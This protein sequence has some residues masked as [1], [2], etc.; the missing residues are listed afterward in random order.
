MCR[1][2]LIVKLE[3]GTYEIAGEQ[4]TVKACSMLPLHFVS[5]KT[6]HPMVQE[7]EPQDFKNWYNTKEDMI[8]PV[9]ESTFTAQG[10]A[11]ILISGNT[12]DAGEWGVAMAA[13]EK[14]HDGKRYVI[15]QADLRQ[16]NPVAK[17]F[18]R[19]IYL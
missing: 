4:V 3:P 5:R 15:C 19:N 9:L 1:Q 13:A 12:N 10:F 14:W 8:T 2:V 16:E 11:P 18:K 7:F 17:R 6:G